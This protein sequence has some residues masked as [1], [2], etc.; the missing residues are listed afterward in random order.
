MGKRDD[1]AEKVEK[2]DKAKKKDKPGKAVAGAGVAAEPMSKSDYLAQLAPLEL[3]LNNLAR[4]LQ[5]TG[6]RLV[7]VLEGRDTSGKGGVISAIADTLNPRQCHVVALKVP[8]A[9]L[10]LGRLGQRHHMALARVEGI[11]NRRYHTALARGVPSLQHQAAPGVL[12]DRKSV[13]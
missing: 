8:L 1:K 7:V 2:S 4:W 3:Q 11:G 12:Q 13:V 5:H 6:R 10:T 9:Q